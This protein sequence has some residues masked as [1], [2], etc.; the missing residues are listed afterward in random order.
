MEHS[1]PQQPA[2]VERPDPNLLQVRIISP[3]KMIYAGNASSVSSVNSAGKF[4]IL[5]QH[6]NFITLIKNTPINLVKLSGELVTFNFNLAIIL[7]I[8][9]SV[10]I[11]SDISDLSQAGIK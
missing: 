9:N 11:Y 5:S 7:A 1:T 4:D 3:K 8:N 10:T 2:Q 6:A